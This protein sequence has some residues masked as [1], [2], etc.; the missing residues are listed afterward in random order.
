MII[1]FNLQASG[2]SELC[3]VKIKKY[4]IYDDDVIY[5][6]QKSFGSQLNYSP[7]C[8]LQQIQSIRKRFHILV[9]KRLSL[10]FF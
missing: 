3:R 6:S 1:L 5:V 4:L 7:F 2:N 9:N 10:L 8:L